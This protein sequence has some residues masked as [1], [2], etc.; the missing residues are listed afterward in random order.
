MS[1]YESKLQTLHVCECIYK[2][3]YVCMYVSVPVSNT[4]VFFTYHTSVCLYTDMYITLCILHMPIV[5]YE[6]LI[7]YVICVLSPK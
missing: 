2:K 3:M 1:I 6:Q 4:C 7:N 5:S